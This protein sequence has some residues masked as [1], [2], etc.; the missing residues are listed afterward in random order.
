MEE[1][2]E[3]AN[4]AA[5]VDMLILFIQENYHSDLPLIQLEE[6]YKV[7][8]RHQIAQTIKYSRTVASIDNLP[9]EM[10]S[11]GYPSSNLATDLNGKG[12]FF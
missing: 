7:K 12:I 4:I 6:K 11:I 5:K 9:N 10:P 3:P 1:P 2:Y 8:N